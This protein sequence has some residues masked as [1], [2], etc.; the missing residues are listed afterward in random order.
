MSI[1]QWL[2]P[3]PRPVSLPC[4]RRPTTAQHGYGSKRQQLRA[5]IHRL[6]DSGTKCS[7]PA[8]PDPIRPGE[9]WDDR[10]DRTGYAGPSHARVIGPSRETCA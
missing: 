10:D 6:T 1:M 9:P 4:T 3:A 2:W 5:R 8:A 7:A